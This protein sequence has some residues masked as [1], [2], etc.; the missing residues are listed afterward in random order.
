M[1]ELAQK[2]ASQSEKPNISF[3]CMDVKD[4]NFIGAFDVIFSNFAIQW[5]PDLKI[6]FRKFFDALK[7][8][9]RIIFSAAHGAPRG[10]IWEHDIKA[11][12]QVYLREEYRKYTSSAT[13]PGV[14]GFISVRPLERMLAKCGFIDIKTGTK[15][16]VLQFPSLKASLGFSYL[17]WAIPTYRIFP[18]DVGDGLLAK[19]DRLVTEQFEAIPD[20][21][22][23]TVLTLGFHASIMAARKPGG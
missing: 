4:I 19:K 16:I 13:T 3:K 18:A 5:F 7:P 15:D 22:K 23:S 12:T 14:T 6:T 17:A 10:D 20:D 2:T 21:Q 1:V 8:G 11:L 9:G